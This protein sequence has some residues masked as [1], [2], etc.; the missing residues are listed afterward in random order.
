LEEHFSQYRIADG[1]M[2]LY[3]VIW[4]D[5]CSW[6]L[7]IIK[8]AFG[9]P[10]DH[11]TYQ[12]TVHFFE[13]LMKILHPYLPFITEEIWQQLDIRKDGV[14]IMTTSYPK[15]K[16]FDNAIVSDFEFAKELI[17]TIRNLK[18]KY[19]LS[20]KTPLNITL[21]KGNSHLL[22]YFAPVLK[23]IVHVSID[24][25]NDISQTKYVSFILGTNEFTINIPL[26]DGD[27]SN[28]DEIEKEIA[29]YEQFLAGIRKKLSNER[30]V[31]GAPQEVLSKEQKKEQDVLKKLELLKKQLER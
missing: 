19:K 25:L 17:V 10:I 8:P 18:S 2:L 16:Q 27:S 15:V 24:N 13:E 22:N 5:F 11:G 4:D 28:T 12:K 9:E 1:L 20:P 30:F 6:Y 14:S 31:S 26:E 29:Y 23:A 21:S 3:R 7:E